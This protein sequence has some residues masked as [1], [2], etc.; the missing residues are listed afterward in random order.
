[1]KD[2]YQ[3]WILSLSL[4]LHKFHKVIAGIIY[5]SGTLFKNTLF[6]SLIKKTLPVAFILLSFFG[7]SAQA[8]TVTSITLNPNVVYSGAYTT[9]TITLSGAYPAGSG[10]FYLSS[11][12]TAIAATPSSIGGFAGDTQETFI[13]DVPLLTG[14]N[15]Q[16][17]YITVTYAGVPTSAQLTV[18]PYSGETLISPTADSYVQ[19]GSSH[20]ANFGTST[21]LVVKTASTPPLWI[22]GLPTSNSISQLLRLHPPKRS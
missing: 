10:A 6:I 5:H 22:H 1:M 15:T 2:R 21:N 11:S 7:T 3:P 12:N 17:V 4:S 20:A 16:T 9:A 14:E 18:V 8:I 13:V 19:A